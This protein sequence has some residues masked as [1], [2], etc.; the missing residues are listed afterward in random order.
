MAASGSSNVVAR[1]AID[2]ISE[3]SGET[4]TVK[5][6]KAFILQ[7]ISESRHLIKVIRDEVDVAKIAL[8]QGLQKDDGLEDYGF[9]SED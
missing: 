3:C 7:E 2:E 8:G 1:P 4:K 5:Y 9:E 6:M